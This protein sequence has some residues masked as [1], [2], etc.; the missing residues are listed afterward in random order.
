MITEIN[1]VAKC[2]K[3]SGVHNKYYADIIGKYWSEQPSLLFPEQ[4]GGNI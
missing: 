2:S 3:V 1:D 4:I